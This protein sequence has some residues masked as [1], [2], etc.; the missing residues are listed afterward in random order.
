MNANELRIGSRVIVNDMGDHYATVITIYKD[1]VECEYTDYDGGKCSM[2]GPFESIAP[3]PL[4]E[5][6]LLKCGFEVWTTKRETAERV[7]EIETYKDYYIHP[8]LPKEMRYYLPYFNM[9]IFIGY[10]G[11]KHLH[12]MQN[13]VYAIT[14]TELKINL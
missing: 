8:L 4:T 9:S 6:I 10:V 3:I 11:I 12:T 7:V 14:G 13:F 5:E 1:C 2:S